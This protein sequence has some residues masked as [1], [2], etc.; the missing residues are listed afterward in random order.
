MISDRHGAFFF[1]SR[2]QRCRD[3]RAFL[4]FQVSPFAAAFGQAADIIQNPKESGHPRLSRR[5]RLKVGAGHWAYMASG[6][7]DD[8]TIHANRQGFRRIQLRPRRLV[9]AT[10]ADR[11]ELWGFRRRARFSMSD[12]WAARIRHRWRTC[13][14]LRGEESRDIKR[15]FVV[16]LNGN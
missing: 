7:D 10:K 15:P 13:R 3:R 5:A 11:M 4:A 16:E 9:D 12:G 1:V 14:E 2:P 8:A 6:V